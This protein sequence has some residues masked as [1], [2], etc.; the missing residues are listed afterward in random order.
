MNHIPIETAIAL[1][2]LQG[3][4]SPGPVARDR[5]GREVYTITLTKGLHGFT[6]HENP[7]EFDRCLKNLRAVVIGLHHMRNTTNVHTDSGA[8]ESTIPEDNSQS[9]SAEGLT[10]AVAANAALLS[11]QEKEMAEVKSQ[12][13]NL[14]AG[15]DRAVVEKAKAERELS[16]AKAKALKLVEEL[17]ETS[18]WTTLTEQEQEQRKAAR[19]RLESVLSQYL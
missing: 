1:N 3:N 10:E 5:K 13:E 8:T 19:A 15:A 7:A 11:R 6:I 14:K 4:F 18:R 12:I 17:A 16:E 2:V 9:F